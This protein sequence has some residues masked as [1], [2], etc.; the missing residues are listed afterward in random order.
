MKAL[1]QHGRKAFFRHPMFQRNLAVRIFMYFMFGILAIELLAFSFV[2]DILLLE[3]GSYELAI[4]AFNTCLIF[5]FVADFSIKFVLKKSQS[6]QIAPYLT[7]PIPRNK[8]FNFLL[9]K[10]LKNVWNLYPMFLLIIFGIKAITPHFGFGDTLLYLF[11]FYLLCIA[12]SLLVNISNIFVER[13]VWLYALPIGIVAGLVGLFFITGIDGFTSAGVAIGRF[14]FDHELIAVAIVLAW[15]AVLW[16]INQRFMRIQVYQELDSAEKTGKASSANLSFFDRF[17]EIGMFMALDIKLITRSKRLRSSLYAILFFIAYYFFMILMK[18]EHNP[19]TENPFMALFFAIFIIGGAGLI[20]GQYIFTTES[21]FMDGLMARNHSLLP[22]LR[23][24]YYLYTG[25]GFVVSLILLIAVFVLQKLSLLM[26]VSTFFYTVGVVFFVVFQCA[27]YNKEYFDL[28]AGNAFSWKGTTSN[29]LFLTMIAMFVPLA[30]VLIVKAV[31]SEQTAL[32][33]MLVSG[34]LFTLLS[35]K[36]LAWTYR[37]FLKRRYK[38][39]EG[40]RSN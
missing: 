19:I 30:I 37:R 15:V 4:D 31:F 14:L 35:E 24:K 10:E 3:S 7:L 28:M 23:A 25:I 39:M 13:S 18:S 27:V 12:N 6:M 32:Y 22:L 17:G 34:L 33:T 20:M 29:T 21:S 8:L 36:W 11:C 38:N 5:F 2:F 40:F 16:V 9:R 26:L 1:A